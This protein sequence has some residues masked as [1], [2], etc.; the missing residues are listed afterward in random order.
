MAVPRRCSASERFKPGQRCHL[1]SQHRGLRRKTGEVN[2]TRLGC[3]LGCQRCAPIGTKW[4]RHA[5]SYCRWPFYQIVSGAFVWCRS[6]LG[7]ISPNPERRHIR[8]ARP[9]KVGDLFRL[10]LLFRCPAPSMPAAGP[11]GNGRPD[12]RAGPWFVYRRDD[13]FRP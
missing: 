5:T 11:A 10:I 7:F 13:I 8:P 3:Q 9:A 1:V 2:S 6:I 12:Q 4:G